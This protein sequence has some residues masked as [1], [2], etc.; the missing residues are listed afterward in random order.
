MNYI[1]PDSTRAGFLVGRRGCITC[2]TAL[3]KGSW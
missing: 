2:L 1:L 3:G